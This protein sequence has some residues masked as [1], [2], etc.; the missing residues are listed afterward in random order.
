MS[1][2]LN[3]NQK[4]L[5]VLGL[6]A[7][8]AV[9]VV[10]YYYS[11]IWNAALKV[12]EKRQALASEQDSLRF[13]SETKN[14]IV[15]IQ[16]VNDEF[17][18]RLINKENPVHFIELVENTARRLGVEMVIQNVSTEEGV[19]NK[20]ADVSYDYITMT[21]RVSGSLEKVRAFLE[22]FQNIPHKIDIEFLRISKQSVAQGE[23]AAP[24]EKWNAELSFKGLTQ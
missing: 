2:K 10:A 13:L 7:C 24:T 5:I 17:D 4:I 14:Q 9:G 12:Q 22:R 18:E 11:F 23:G 20:A 8:G 15:E 21:V 3:T 6:L 16:K 19:V 1:I